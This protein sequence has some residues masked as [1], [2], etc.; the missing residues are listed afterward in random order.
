MDIVHIRKLDAV[1]GK[2]LRLVCPRVNNKRLDLILME[3][4]YD[5]LNL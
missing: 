1:F 3:S 4:F 2:C 5:I